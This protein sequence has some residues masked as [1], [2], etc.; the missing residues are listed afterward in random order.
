VPTTAKVGIGSRGCGLA[1]G[2]EFGTPTTEVETIDETAEARIAELE[3]RV[4]HLTALLGAKSAPLGPAA[5]FE[6]SLDTVYQAT[7]LGYLAVY[8]VS[9]RT[10]RIRLLVG[11]QNP[12]ATV[13]G[14]V[15]TR[16][17]IN[18]YAGAVIRPGEFWTAATPR[19]GRK[20]GFRCVFTPLV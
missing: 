20:A 14:E 9:G 5:R 3:G 12:P 10:S 16:S 11:P 15:D 1:S 13:V 7:S 4:A 8:F 6:A 18:S 2:V 17:D 19:P